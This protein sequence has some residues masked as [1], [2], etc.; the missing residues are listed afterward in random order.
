MIRGRI[1][2]KSPKNCK[3]R[4]IADLS[5]EKMGLKFDDLP[6]LADVDNIDSPN[7][8]SGFSTT[9]YIKTSLNGIDFS[10]PTIL[11]DNA[12]YNGK[13]FEFE[14]RIN[15]F[16]LDK[17]YLWLNGWEISADMPDLNQSGQATSSTSGSIGILYQIPFNEIPITQISIL[18]S[19]QGDTAILEE[20]G[21]SGF[22]I[23]ILNKD[24]IAVKR[25]FNYIARGY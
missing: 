19:E 17:G 7:S 5:F 22:S 25:D 14:L 15:K 12:S 2:L 21:L 9:T 4:S 1:E 3:L 11:R 23:K 13:Y 20:Q 6:R 24:S 8:N 16:G 18:Q 10:L